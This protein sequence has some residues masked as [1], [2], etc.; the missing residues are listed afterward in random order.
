MNMAPIVLAD[1]QPVSAPVS[2]DRFD[3]SALAA[4]LSQ[5]QHLYIAGDMQKALMLSSAAYDEG[6]AVQGFAKRVKAGAET[7]SKVGDMI[8]EAL[9]IECYALIA[10]VN[11]LD[12][13]QKAGMI[14]GKGRPKNVRGSDIFKLDD[15]GIDRRRLQE[16]RKLRDAEL[17]RPGV[18]RW[19]IQATRAKGALPSRNNL[20]AAVGTASASKDERGD[21]FYQTPVVAT[22]TLLALE[23]FG[24]TIWEPACGLGAVSRV[25]EDKGYDVILSDLVDR[26]LIS[27]AGD[28]QSVGDFLLSKPEGEGDRPDIITNPPY[29]EVLNAFVAHALRVH[30]PSKMALLLNSNF[31]FGF[32][33]E[34]RNFVME[35][36]PPSRIYKFKR[37]L[38]MMHR[39]G[40]EGPKAPS[41]M[42]TAWFVWERNADGTYGDPDG[43][44]KSRRVDWKDYV[45]SDALDPGEGGH[46][47]GID[48]DEGPRVTPR[49]E[50]HERVD[51]DRDDAVAWIST[52]TEFTRT[53]LC[54]GIGR[55]DSTVEAIIAELVVAGRISA[56]SAPGRDGRHS[57]ID[58][59]KAVAA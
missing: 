6:K 2:L 44:T 37:R 58:L 19:N 59:E 56:A 5:A 40:Y 25:L 35:E 14:A 21:N 3:T 39:E 1:P 54:R 48:F 50:L 42:N 27:E 45:H 43:W 51:R 32:D 11:E 20:R 8:A 38:P 15:V 52:R 10:V 23:S 30:K 46:S 9:E 29:G 57:V 13:A 49:L 18:I 47:S 17:L 34:D 55:R 53:E 7:I 22:L 28:V 16:A 31:E 33:D 12:Q 41:R 24:S 36:Y 26:G 4:K